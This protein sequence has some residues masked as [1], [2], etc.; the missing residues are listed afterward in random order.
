[1]FGVGLEGAVIPFE[2][3]LGALGPII[4]LGVLGGGGSAGERRAMQT[5]LR[6]GVQWGR[7]L[8]EILGILSSLTECRL[9]I[10]KRLY[11]IL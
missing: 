1:M 4:C 9:M 5:E 10:D 8:E 7:W 11:R 6:T 3:A 2:E